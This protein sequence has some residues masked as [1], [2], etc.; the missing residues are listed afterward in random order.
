M[1]DNELFEGSRFIRLAQLVPGVLPV[2]PSSVW[3]WV[4]KK[5][6]PAPIKLAPGVTAWRWSDV[7]AWLAARAATRGTP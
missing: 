7:K 5:T 4:R 2:S 6:F 3:R 1:E